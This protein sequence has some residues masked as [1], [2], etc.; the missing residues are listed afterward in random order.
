[1]SSKYPPLLLKYLTQYQENPKSRI[2]AP[3]AE[4]Y[5]KIGLVDEAIQICREG[6]DHHPTFIGGKVA[7]ARALFDKKRHRD[8]R[9]LLKDAI[10]EIPD[11]LLAQRLLADSNLVL[12]FLDEALNAYKMI[13]YFN[14]SDE[15]VAGMVQELETQSYQGGGLL[16]DGPNPEK[17]RKLLRLQSLLSRVQ[18]AQHSI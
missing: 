2:F 3:L 16:K 11:N 15:E 17:M 12:G 8:V 6:L 5:R 18:A 13:L 10:N 9:E 1:M 14:P 7:L 4:A